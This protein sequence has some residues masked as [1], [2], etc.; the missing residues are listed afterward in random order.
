MRT[1]RLFSSLSLLAITMVGCATTAQLPSFCALRRGMTISELRQMPSSREM[2]R[3]GIRA[4]D[5]AETGSITPMETHDIDFA[6]GSEH[7]TSRSVH[8]NGDVWDVL[9]YWVVV[10]V[11]T[12]VDFRQFRLAGPGILDH[13]E[14][15]VFKN[16]KLVGWGLGYPPRSLLRHPDQVVSR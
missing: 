15:T 16:H 4:F 13:R 3:C 6:F 8:I 10:P 11:T 7:G 9:T 14:Y 1:G 5:V 12:N 2:N